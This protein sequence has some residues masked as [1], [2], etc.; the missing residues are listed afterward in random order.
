MRIRISYTINGAAVQE[1]AEVN[2]FP[3]DVWD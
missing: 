1:Q 3:T 2:N